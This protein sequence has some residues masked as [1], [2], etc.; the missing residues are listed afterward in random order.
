MYV[1]GA[2]LYG[3]RTGRRELVVSA[4]RGVYCIAGLLLLAMV[5]LE[6]AYARSD[7]SFKLVAQNSSTDTPTFYKFTALWSSQQ[8][9][10]LLW[11]LLLSV[12]SSV[13]LHITRRK[14]R[15]IVPYATAVL[16]GVAA[17]FL[18]LITVWHQHRSA[19][20]PPA[21]AEANGLEP[22]LRHPAMMIHPP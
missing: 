20:L 16:G 5:V 6:A 1:V 8:G 11:A 7:F 9:S 10:L 19:A 4:R 15:E 12:Y 22:L 13:A 2:S 14:H 18:A 17:F 3:A 21:R